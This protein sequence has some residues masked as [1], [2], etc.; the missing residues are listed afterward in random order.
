MSLPASRPME[1]S[2]QLRFAIT[3]SVSVTP[4]KPHSLQQNFVAKSAVRARPA[5]ADTVEGGHGGVRTALFHR[6]LEPFR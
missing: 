2:I 4:T 6:V 5:R 3:A 1:T